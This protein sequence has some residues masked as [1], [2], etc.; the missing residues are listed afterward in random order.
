LPTK[1][2]KN[3]KLENLLGK[4]TLNVILYD[5]SF[6][7]I[8][9]FAKIMSKWHE[10]I[11]YFDFDLLYSGY[12]TA[13]EIHLSKNITVFSP[14]SDNLLENL[15]SVIDK[16]SKTKSLIVLDSLNGF[17]NLLEGKNDVAR[18]V[19]SFVMLLVSSAKDVK[20][21]VVVASL[22]KLNDENEWV[23]HNTGRHVLENDHMTKIQLT[24][25][26]NQ[27]LAKTSNPDSLILE[28]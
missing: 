17:F 28:I 1:T 25:S 22:S 7:K 19:N 15:K 6:T 24:Q 20:S 12:V 8:R 4:N 13:K 10:P 11:F 3:I 21:C 26:D 16:T 9:F 2:S 18:L 27:I 14:N 5:D 23:L